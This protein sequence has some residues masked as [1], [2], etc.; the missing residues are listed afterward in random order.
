MIQ[1]GPGTLTLAQTNF[2][3]GATTINAGTLALAGGILRP[4]AS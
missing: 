3:A 1:N 2:Y 4:R